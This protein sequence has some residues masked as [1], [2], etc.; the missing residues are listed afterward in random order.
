MLL[1]VC[2]RSLVARL[3]DRGRRLAVQGTLCVVTEDQPL[4]RAAL[5]PIPDQTS[6]TPQVW[7]DRL[8]ADR[9][10]RFHGSSNAQS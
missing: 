7:A 3:R 6:D 8:M 9:D 10:W 1:V 2:Q 4:K 5:V